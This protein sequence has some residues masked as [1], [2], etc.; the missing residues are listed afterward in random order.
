MRE[1]GP[2]GAASLHRVGA[3]A[4][5]ARGRRRAARRTSGCWRLTT[6][7]S[8][9]RSPSR[10]GAASR[11]ARCGSWR[12]CCTTWRSRRRGASTPTA[13]P[14]SSATTG[15]APS[16]LTAIAARLRWPGRAGEVLALLVRQ[17]LRPMHLGMLD[18]VS[19]RARYRFHRDVGE[20]VAGARVPHHRRRGRHRRPAARPR[21]PWR[22]AGP[23]RVAPGRRARRRA[24]RRPSRPWC[25]AG[26]SW[27]RSGSRR[28]PRSG[29]ALRRA[30][31]AQALGLVR[32][33]EEALAW[34][35]RARRRGAKTHSAAEAE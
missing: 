2:V 9:R 19:R 12:S 7:G 30:R 24:R 22:D 5:G 16:G 11:A 10:W 35:A 20:E 4:P 6:R 21:L 8:R 32:T 25:A 17:H 27:P 31:E 15:S 14:A 3:L 29:S 34:L 13:A 18:E 33:R 23:A 26:T 28:D 1:R